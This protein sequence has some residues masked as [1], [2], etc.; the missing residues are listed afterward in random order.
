MENRSILKIIITLIL[1]LVFVAIPASATVTTYY[2][3]ISTTVIALYNGS[4]STTW[5]APPWVTDVEYVVVA[6]AGGGGGYHGGGGGSGGLLNGT[7]PV[8]P[9]IVYNLTIGLGGIPGKGYDVTDPGNGQN[10]SFA[11]YSAVDGINARGGGS[12]GGIDAAPSGKAGG[13][14][15]G[16]RLGGAGVKG[17]G[18]AGQGYDG[19]AGTYGAPSNGA[20]GGGGAGHTGYDANATVSGWGGDGILIYTTGIPTWF[21]GGGGAGSAQFS[22]SGGYYGVGG[23]G[24]G[25]NGSFIGQNANWGVN[26]TGGGG[27]GS[28][29]N[30]NTKYGGGGGSGVVIIK[31]TPLTPTGNFTSNVTT[32]VVSLGVQFN[33]TSYNFIPTNWNWTF[34]DGNYSSIQNPVATFAFPGVF[35]VTL[36]ASNASG[37]AT[38]TKINYITASVPSVPTVDFSANVTSG[39]RPLAVKFTEA[40]TN[41][42]HNAMAWDWSF[43]DGAGNSTDQNPVRTFTTVGYYD[44]NLIATNDIGANNTRKVGYINV[45]DYT[46]FNRQDLTLSTSYTLALEIRDNDHALITQNVN[47]ETSGI[48]TDTYNTSSGKINITT[49]YGLLTVYVTSADYYGR[50]ETYVTDHDQTDTIY[51]TQIPEQGK[52]NTWYTPHQVRFTVI[53]QYGAPVQNST[54][55]ANAIN[56]TIPDIWLQTMYG[57][58]P[59]AANDMLNGTLIMQ[60]VTS[61]DGAI[62]F[63]MHGS[64]RY[65]INIIDPATGALFSTSVMPIGADY[66]IRTSPFAFPQVS[67]STYSKIANTTLTFSEPNSSYTTLGL[68]YQDTS[69]STTS[70]KFYVTAVHNRT[71]VYSADL[72]NPGTAVRY[73]NFTLRN[74]RG[75]QYIWNY[76]AV[77]T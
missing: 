47:I 62:V 39:I 46:G 10:S 31:Y 59:E 71:V 74:E 8:T 75:Y 25:G 36:D 73:A 63:T 1:I 66:P 43:G 40:S 44:I 56:A 41:L 3:N 32:G 13:S 28:G 9:G 4:G 60:G 61:T 48:D 65:N 58:N 18:T 2:F 29:S 76:T 51:L 11:N 72:G 17:V 54:V 14:G 5:T 24:G 12:G 42:S 22:G 69:G 15:G 20:G 19:G 57:I 50:Y 70:L 26:G 23:N 77:R 37:N 30:D 38:I 7:M 6:G 67:N 68:I 34:G 35:T 45:S 53:D 55:S 27:G 64:I 21:A 49:D 16:A 33:D 52:M